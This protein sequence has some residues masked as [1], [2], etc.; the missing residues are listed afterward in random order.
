MSHN[1]DLHGKWVCPTNMSENDSYDEDNVRGVEQGIG[2]TKVIDVDE[3]DFS[4]KKK[5]AGAV[6]DTANEEGLSHVWLSLTL[7]FVM[8][9]LFTAFL[10]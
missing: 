3:H 2:D 8:G 5:E 10:L 1:S 7:F 9:G 4:D 6:L